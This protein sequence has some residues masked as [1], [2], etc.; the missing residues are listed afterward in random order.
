MNGILTLKI[1]IKLALAINRENGAR[2]VFWL[3]FSGIHK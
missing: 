1:E 3:V 2:P